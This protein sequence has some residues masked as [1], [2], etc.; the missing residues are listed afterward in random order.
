MQ[1][2]WL[3]F[4]TW[5]IWCHKVS[6]LGVIWLAKVSTLVRFDVTKFLTFMS[7]DLP[8]F[9]TFVWF[10]QT[11]FLTLGFDL[12]TLVM[13]QPSTAD[14]KCTAI[15]WS[16]GRDM[17]KSR[18]Y[19]SW[20][21]VY[22]VG[23]QYIYAGNQIQQCA[24]CDKGQSMILSVFRLSPI[25]YVLWSVTSLKVPELCMSK[26]TCTDLHASFVVV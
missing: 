5:L 3:K 13:L 2:V 24:N 10:D 8:K 19:G 12:P 1:F 25:I 16:Y 4:L 14:R 23:V 7:F 18:L 21:A 22:C 20:R 26:Y 11:K 9:L 15:S 6:N 17:R